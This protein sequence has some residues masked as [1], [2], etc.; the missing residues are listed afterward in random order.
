[1]TCA[2]RLLPDLGEE[3]KDDSALEKKAERA[4]QTGKSNKSPLL[5]ASNYYHPLSPLP[6]EIDHLVTIDSGCNP[7]YVNYDSISR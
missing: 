7:N 5:A 3:I 1:M 4:K 6:N 2:T